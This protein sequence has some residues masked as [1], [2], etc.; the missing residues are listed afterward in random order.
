MSLDRREQTSADPTALTP[1]SKVADLLAQRIATLSRA[2][3][4]QAEAIIAQRTDMT[5]LEARILAY[6][7]AN[8]PTAI[9]DLAAR[10]FIDAAQ[11][12]RLT[13]KLVARGYLQRTANVEDQ[14]VIYLSLSSKGR[15]AYERMQRSASAWNKAL[16]SQ[17]KSP[18]IA[19]LDRALALLTEY[20]GTQLPS[21]SRRRTSA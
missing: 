10:M 17:L 11:A 3:D 12:S 1:G 19:V 9:R 14:R 21:A 15:A 18:E 4:R 7:Q 16:L 6:V 8:E 20:V 2:L 13:S 5:L